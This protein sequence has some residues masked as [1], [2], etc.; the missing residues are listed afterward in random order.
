MMY[1]SL[2]VKLVVHMTLIRSSNA[3]KYACVIDLHCATFTEALLGLIK[4]CWIMRNC[5]IVSYV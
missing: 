2:E 4:L 1:K 3:L 5:I